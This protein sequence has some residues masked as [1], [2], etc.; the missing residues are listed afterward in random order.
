[1]DKNGTETALSTYE[2]VA[3]L[4]EYP[5]LNRMFS[6]EEIAAGC[7]VARDYGLAAII[8]RPTDVDAAARWMQDSS[9]AVGSVA[10]FPSGFQTTAVKLY[11]ARDLLR[12][13][14][15]E[16]E[17]VLNIG[18]LFSRQ[19]Q[20]LETELL[21]LVQACQEAGALLKVEFASS[22]LPEDLKTIA[23]KLCNRTGVHFATIDSAD[24]LP[25]IRSRC[26]ERVRIKATEV[27]SLDQLLELNAAGCSRFASSNPAL[28]LEEWKAR[29]AAIEQR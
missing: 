4:L 22:S 25:L 17:A 5:L 19:F 27:A 8:V 7:R 21:Q 20:Y 16:I 28:L 11:E 1:M 9:V 24:E 26:K 14:A 15:K 18:K 2:E 12:R 29:L 3:S 6:E 13:G 10:G 23:C